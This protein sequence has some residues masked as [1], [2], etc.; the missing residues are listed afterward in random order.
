LRR[1][2]WLKFLT[3]LAGT[4]LVLAPQTIGPFNRFTSRL[5]ARWTLRLSALITTRDALSTNALRQLGFHGQVIEAT[6]VALRL[7]FEQPA[8]KTGTK[9]RVGLNVS[10]LL[11][12]GG[13]TGTNELGI[14]LDYPKLMRHLIGHFVKLGCEVHLVPHVIVQEG[15]M[16]REDDYSASEA[17]A[18]EFQGVRIAPA[19]ANPSA[20]KTYIAGMDFFLGARMHACIAAFSAGVPVVPLAY[21]RKFAGLFGSLGYHH[22]IDCTTESAETALERAVVAFENRTKLAD[23][24]RSAFAVGLGKL[25]GYETALLS[26]MEKYDR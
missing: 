15:P 11:M 23:E 17:L 6:D 14:R 25:T 16:V 10:G 19:F 26:M 18:A 3:H 1:I 9:I 22:T 21:S 4:P 13:Y 20:A 5:L 2:F 24:V 12:G 7:P 8:Q